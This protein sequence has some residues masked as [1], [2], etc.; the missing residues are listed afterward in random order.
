M[1][2]F[3]AVAQNKLRHLVNY[4]Y[5]NPDIKLAFSASKVGHF[6]NVKDSVTQG[7][8]SRTVVLFIQIITN[9][10][11]SCPFGNIV[12]LLLKHRTIPLNS[13]AFPM[14]KTQFVSG[15]MYKIPA[16]DHSNEHSTSRYRVLST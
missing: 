16:C 4:Y 8:R 2:R 13:F 3:F 9:F 1:G 10:L 6:F 15:H 7:L 11:L 5:T 12:Y 14:V